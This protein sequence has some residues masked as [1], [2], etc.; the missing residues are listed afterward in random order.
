M[1]VYVVLSHYTDGS[2]DADTNIEAIYT[3]KAAAHAFIADEP[4]EDP[5]ISG[6]SWFTIEDWEVEE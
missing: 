4:Q 6:G 5:G 3:S 2:P 1:K